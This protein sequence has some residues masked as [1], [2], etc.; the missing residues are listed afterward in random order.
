MKRE[1]LIVTIPIPCEIPKARGLWATTQ[2]GAIVNIR[3]HVDE[4]E[5]IEQE[6]GNL[7]ISKAA[8]TRWCAVK[9][10]EALQERRKKNAEDTG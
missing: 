9:V 6:A 3:M 8:F 2:F 10:A 1:D 7:G 4:R 5:L